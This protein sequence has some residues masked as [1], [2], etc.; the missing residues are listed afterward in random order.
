MKLQDAFVE[1]ALE[2]MFFDD[3]PFLV[4]DLEGK[5]FVWRPS[6]EPD[7]DRVQSFFDVL[8]V[9]LGCSVL[10]SQVWVEDV[11]FVPLNHFWR[12]IVCIVMGLI[13]FVPLESGFDR[14]VVLWLPW[15]EL[16]G[17]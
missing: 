4:D 15:Q 17:P 13:V 8:Q 16:V 9:E 7:D 2:A 3:V 1:D 11:E 5:V 14:V 10:I 12:W 6:S